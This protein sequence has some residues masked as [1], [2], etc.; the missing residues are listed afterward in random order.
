MRLISSARG[1]TTG[2]PLAKGLRASVTILR[3]LSSEPLPESITRRITSSGNPW[4]FK[5][6][7]WLIIAMCSSE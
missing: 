7:T 5:F 3:T 6:L 2:S 4:D 1:I